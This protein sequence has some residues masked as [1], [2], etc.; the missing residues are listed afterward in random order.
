MINCCAISSWHFAFWI[1]ISRSLCVFIRACVCVCVHVE[2]FG[3]KNTR[4]N[5][6]SKCTQCETMDI[7][8]WQCQ[9][10]KFKRRKQ[11]EK[12]HDSAIFLLLFS[13]WLLFFFYS[14]SCV[15]FLCQFI[16]LCVGFIADG[17]CCCVD[18]R[19]CVIKFNDITW[20]DVYHTRNLIYR[21]QS[22][23]T[24]RRFIESIVCDIQ[25][26][27][28]RFLDFYSLRCASVKLIEIYVHHEFGYFTRSPSHPSIVVIVFI[29]QKRML[30]SC[31][32]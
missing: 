6:Q 13:H 31:N 4:E 22:F 15:Q 11:E 18:V 21:W 1:Y 10:E 19:W 29:E 28:L 5:K 8:R 27:V 32:Y 14:R 9:C 16:W 25:R 24:F 3:Q 26:S 20:R 2:L 30:F 17:L 23:H 12:Q 7:V